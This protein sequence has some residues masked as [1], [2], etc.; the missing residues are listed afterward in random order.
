MR[1]AL[2]LTQRRGRPLP[3]IV[4]WAAPFKQ[5]G[6]SHD[7]AWDTSSGFDYPVAGHL[8]WGCLVLKAR[9]T[10]WF[11]GTLLMMCPEMYSS[12][13]T[14]NIKAK[15]H[16]PTIHWHNG[17]FTITS[18]VLWFLKNVLK[19]SNEVKLQ[20]IRVGA[21]DF[22]GATCLCSMQDTSVIILVTTIHRF[23]AH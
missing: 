7:W 17:Q 4:P 14:L 18:H 23:N 10:T 12:H 5:P 6:N 19:Y 22:L 16:V 3:C 13:A 21:I 8:W 2:C 11:K 15:P 20:A 9:N 1:S